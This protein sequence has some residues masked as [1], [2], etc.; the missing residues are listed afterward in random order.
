MLMLAAFSLRSVGF[1]HL[2]AGTTVDVALRYLFFAGIA[3]LLGYRLFRNRWLHRKIIARLPQSADVR[4]EMGYSALTLV[5]FGLMGAATIVAS[6]WGWTRMYWQVS[7][8]GWGWFWG[9]V[10]CT[11]FLHDAY[12]Y[13][14][15]RLM[16]HPKLFNAFHRVHHLSTNPTPWAAYSFAPLEAVVEAGIFPV[17]V[18]VMP[19]HP[20][21][22]TVVMLWQIVFNVLGHTGYEFHPRWLMNSRLRFL[23]NTPTNHVMHHEKLRGNYG[24]YF[25]LWDRLMGTNHSDYEDRF[26]EVTSRLPAQTSEVPAS[27]AA[28]LKGL[29]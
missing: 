14:T 24:L 6:Q 7:D 23:L 18:C 25:N 13:W 29:S 4:R 2:S 17:A 28:T 11:I 27:N 26:R 21:A 22:F 10:V 19:L 8:Y 16:H 9:S 3:W 15:H 12:F 5:I 1:L 20:L